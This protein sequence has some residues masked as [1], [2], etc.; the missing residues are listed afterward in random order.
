MAAA[1]SVGPITSLTRSLFGHNYTE[2]NAQIKEKFA[3]VG[4]IDALRPFEDVN[5]ILCIEEQNEQEHDNDAVTYD[6]KVWYYLGK[7]TG[8]EDQTYKFEKDTLELKSSFTAQL[9]FESTNHVQ[10]SNA[11]MTLYRA[12]PGMEFKDIKE[13]KTGVLGGRTVSSP[14]CVFYDPANKF[15]IMLP[16]DFHK[17]GRRRRQNTKKTTRCAKRRRCTNRKHTSSWPKEKKRSRR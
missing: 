17:G 13:A 2:A 1:T 4:S 12:E 5:Y 7:F 3:Q 9:Q 14:A 11:R 8:E 10:R 15:A 6:T 16:S